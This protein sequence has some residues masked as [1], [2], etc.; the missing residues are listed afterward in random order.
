MTHLVFMAAINEQGPL[1]RSLQGPYSTEL[2]AH[3]VF[4]LTIK[5]TPLLHEIKHS[6]WAGCP[7]SPP[8]IY[9]LND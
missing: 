1:Y 2:K 5:T 8:K 3:L 9:L 4:M 6:S 7:S